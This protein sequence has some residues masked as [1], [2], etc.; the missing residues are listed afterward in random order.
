MSKHLLK[1]GPAKRAWSAGLLWNPHALWLGVH[2]SPYNNATVSTLCPA[3]RCGCACLEVRN[4]EAS[5]VPVNR[6]PRYVGL[7]AGTACDQCPPQVGASAKR[8]SHIRYHTA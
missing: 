6:V 5:P 2:Y 8:S 4:H 3:S 1:I 7:H